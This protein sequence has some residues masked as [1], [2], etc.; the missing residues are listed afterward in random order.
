MALVELADLTEPHIK[1]GILKVLAEAGIRTLG[2]MAE[3]Q[4]KDGDFWAKNIK[5]VGKAAQD[6]IADASD[7]YWVRSRASKL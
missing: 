1:V 4:E 7:A 5:G 3:R 2:D 6:S